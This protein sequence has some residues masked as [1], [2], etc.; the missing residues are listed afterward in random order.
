MTDP[1]PPQAEASGGGDDDDGARTSLR[2]TAGGCAQLRPATEGPGRGEHDP[3]PITDLNSTRPTLPT[4]RARAG[5]DFQ[6]AWGV[7]RPNERP[8]RG[9]L[10]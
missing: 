7:G 6:R 5:G 8:T 1:P 9:K 4:K 2:A 3:D 10:T